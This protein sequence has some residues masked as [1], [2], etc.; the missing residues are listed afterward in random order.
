MTRSSVIAL[1]VLAVAFAL[2]AILLSSDAA[3]GEQDCLWGASSI[4]VEADGSTVGPETS[5]CIP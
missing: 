1:A 3:G 2:F 4:S 5:G